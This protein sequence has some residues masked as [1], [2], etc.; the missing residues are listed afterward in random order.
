MQRM[1]DH[2]CSMH[3]QPTYIPK[4]KNISQLASMAGRGRTWNKKDFH[5][6]FWQQRKG[7]L[8]FY[9]LSFFLPR[10]NGKWHAELDGAGGK[11]IRFVSLSLHNLPLFLWS[12]IQL[13]HNVFKC[14]SRNWQVF[15]REKVSKL[16]L[17]GRC[18]VERWRDWIYFTRA[19]LSFRQND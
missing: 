13:W 4:L 15:A 3:S 14:F 1:C 19:M 6:Q 8:C 5:G 18:L 2:V 7:I 9:M 17:G 16:W 11:L 12:N 10:S